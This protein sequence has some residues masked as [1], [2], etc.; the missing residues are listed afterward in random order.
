[1]Y[2]GLTS[3]ANM[4]RSVRKKYLN[5]H[6][7]GLVLPCVFRIQHFTRNEFPINNHDGHARI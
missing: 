1:M 6:A 4:M 5:A 3:S 7:V 2:P